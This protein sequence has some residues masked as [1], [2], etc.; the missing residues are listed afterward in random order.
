VS[1]GGL[2]LPMVVAAV[3]ATALCGCKHGEPSPG[4]AASPTTSSPKQ[5]DDE[6]TRMLRPD[7]AP[8]A[9]G[10]AGSEGAAPSAKPVAGT[11]EEKQVKVTGM[12]RDAKLGAVVIDDAGATWYVEGLERWESRLSGKRV[13]VSGV[14]RE[15][16]LAPDPTVGPKGEVSAGMVGTSRVIT[17]PMWQLAE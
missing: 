8:F 11:V 13:Q 2:L 15:R 16:K 14:A 10:T 7:P 17:R 4:A 9:P 5:P 6:L 1:G 12:A 3:L